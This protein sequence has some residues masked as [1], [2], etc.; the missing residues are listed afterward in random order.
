MPILRMFREK[1]EKISDRTG[2]VR[3]G[4]LVCGGRVSMSN[5][6]WTGVSGAVA[7]NQ[8]VDTI[9]NNL[10]NVNTPGFKKDQLIFQEYL[11]QKERNTP[12][13]VQLGGPIHERHLNPILGADKAMV[14][15]QGSYTD[16]SQGTMSSTSSPLDFAIEGPGYFEIETPQGVRL[17]RRGSFDLLPNGEMVTKEGNFV[18]AP[19]GAKINLLGLQNLSVDQKGQIF[20]EG[21]AVGRF[22]IVEAED[23]KKLVKTGSLLF[24]SQYTTK[25]QTAFDRTKI[26]S[27]YLENSNVNPVSEMTDLIS[28]HRSLEMALKAIRTYSEIQQKEANE[29]GK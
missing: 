3:S 15:V 24:D 4:N 5:G 16:H 6:M 13:P 11:S 23:P 19:G 8:K 26:H 14:A 17:S 20:S 21:N 10:A 22:S 9:A 12:L 28:A 18:L 29:L 27:G 7:Q 25:K 1:G 2:Y